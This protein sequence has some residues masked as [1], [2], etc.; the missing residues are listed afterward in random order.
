MSQYGPGQEGSNTPISQWCCKLTLRFPGRAPQTLELFGCPEDWR[1]C[2]DLHAN[3]ADGCPPPKRRRMRGPRPDDG[4]RDAAVGCVHPELGDGAAQA[5]L[6][7]L[8]DGQV[9]HLCDACE[10]PVCRSCRTALATAPRDKPS[11]KP[12]VPMALAND[13]WYGYV[14]EVIARLD[15]R[16]IECACASLSWTALRGALRP[17]HEFNDARAGGARCRAR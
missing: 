16:W 7:E 3:V 17:P 6:S 4:A 14:Q 13:Q 9:I 8:R 5:S 15:V 10:L 11:V 2:R 1:C 12:S